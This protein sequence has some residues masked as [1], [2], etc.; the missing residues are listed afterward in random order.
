M[1]R[2]KVIDTIQKLLRL[3]EGTSSQAEAES[4]AAKVQELLFKYNLEM[5][6]VNSHVPE[7]E[8]TVGQE[9]FQT[10]EGKNEGTWIQQLYWM[11]SK[12]N[13]CFA[14]ILSHPRKKSETKM[15]VVGRPGSVQAVQYL[16]EWLIP[17]AR[18]LA[19]Q[20]F[21]EYEGW[22][23]KGK[24][25]RG[26]LSGFVIGIGGKLYEEWQAQQSRDENCKALV[27]TS[28][29]E[30]KEYVLNRYPFVG[31]ARRSSS[32]SQ[33]GHTAGVEAGRSTQIRRGIKGDKIGGYLTT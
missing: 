29:K 12:Y 25:T 6:E 28:G 11:V 22:E 14:L 13:F 21:R 20:S 31:R 32:S 16:V 30:V 3:R 9:E 5:A 33:D 15:G 19:K 8:R 17:E 26:F 24:F 27:V 2:E 18:N 4:A 23:K 7:D 10:G 1:N